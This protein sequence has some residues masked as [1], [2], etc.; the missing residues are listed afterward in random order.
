MNKIMCLSL[1]FCYNNLSCNIYIYSTCILRT[2]IEMDLPM[3]KPERDQRLKLVFYM[4]LSSL[5][6]NGE[7][8]RFYFLN[9]FFL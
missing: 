7:S 6:N 2:I 1:D 9:P 5:E 4:L 8:S 3:V